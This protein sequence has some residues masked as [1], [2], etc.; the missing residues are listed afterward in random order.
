MRVTN[1]KQKILKDNNAITLIAL[2]ITI[3]ILLILAGISI[4]ALTQTGLFGKAKEAE[5]KSK[6]ALELENTTLGDYENEINEIVSTGSREESNDN[7]YSLEE[8]IIGTWIDGKKIYR[9]VYTGK[10]TAYNQDLFTVEDQIDALVDIK[11]YIKMNTNYIL[12]INFTQQNSSQAAVFLK[13]DLKTVAFRGAYD[14]N[15]G[16][17]YITLE[18]TKK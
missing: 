12:P 10:V 7:K 6:A 1:D 2:V 16:D 13:P 8:K 18:Y 4:S 11:G 17:F 15:N 14:V 3:I 5:Q 9:R